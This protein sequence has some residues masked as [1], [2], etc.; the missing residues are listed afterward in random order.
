[1]HAIE[2]ALRKSDRSATDVRQTRATDAAHNSPGHEAGAY[3]GCKMHFVFQLVVCPALAALVRACL[4]AKSN[5]IFRFDLKP[6]R[7][8][9]RTTT[10]RKYNDLQEAGG[11]LSPCESVQAN[12]F[13]YRNPYRENKP[14]SSQQFRHLGRRT[15]CRRIG[16]PVFKRMNV[17]VSRALVL[18][19]GFVGCSANLHFRR[20]QHVS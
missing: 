10:I 17:A 18:V 20:A 11:H 7:R 4:S 5:P 8:R 13:T 15:C 1:M 16:A 12:T 2:A 14:Q 19:S 9:E 6:R 3:R